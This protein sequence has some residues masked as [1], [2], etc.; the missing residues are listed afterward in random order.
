MDNTEKL[1]RALLKCE[2]YEI[3]DVSATRSGKIIPDS[4]IYYKVTKK[5]INKQ[6]MEQ[7]EAVNA[8][9]FVKSTL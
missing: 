7:K 9:R 3:E 5:P 6:T 2:G 8:I 1:L 4:V